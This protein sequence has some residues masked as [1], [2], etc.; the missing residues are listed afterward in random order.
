MNINTILLVLDSNRGAMFTH[1]ATLPTFVTLSLNK[2]S[3]PTVLTTARS[4][5]SEIDF[6]H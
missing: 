2:S 3:H 4:F 5:D 6:S 1:L